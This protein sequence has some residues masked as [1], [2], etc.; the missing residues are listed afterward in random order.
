[1]LILQFFHS[2]EICELNV[3]KI[4]CVVLTSVIP[5]FYVHLLLG[6]YMYIPEENIPPKELFETDLIDLLKE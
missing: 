6:L 1:M 4:P 2:Q 3:I 5:V